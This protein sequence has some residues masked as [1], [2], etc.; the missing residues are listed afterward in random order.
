[1]APKRLRCVLCDITA[2]ASWGWVWY[3]KEVTLP[4]RADGAT[5]T[6]WLW[7]CPECAANCGT[8]EDC[9]RFFERFV[10]GELDE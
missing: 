10:A 2:S 4:P 8:T 6:Q 3:G 5:R 9:D 1:M 7:L